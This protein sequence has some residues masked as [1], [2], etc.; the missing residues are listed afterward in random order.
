MWFRSAFLALYSCILITDVFGQQSEQ[1]SSRFLFPPLKA[2]AIE[3]RVG[4]LSQSNHNRLRLDIGNSIDFLNI[5]PTW[6]EHDRMSFGADFFTWT[7]LRQ[8]EN[9]HFPVDAVDYLFGINASYSVPTAMGPELSMRVRLSHISAHLVD[10]S[11]EKQNQ[12]WRDGK[13]PRVYSR[14]FLQVI[15]A[16][17]CMNTYRVYI[18]IEYVYHIDPSDLG[19]YSLQAGA[20]ATLPIPSASWFHPY[21]A[22]DAKLVNVHAWALNHSMQVGAKFGKWYGTGLNIFLAAYS[23]FSMHGEYYDIRWSYVGPGFTV[24]F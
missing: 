18:G 17:T 6:L 7:S 1:E 2:N 3:A 11:Y 13:L 5:M 23:G 8:A 9:F 16:I 10:G 12:T 21:I 4:A 14:E 24:E 20:E 22:Y 19:K 15:S